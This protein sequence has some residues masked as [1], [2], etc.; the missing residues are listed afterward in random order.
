MI[1]IPR[2][3]AERHGL[4]V[5]DLSYDHTFN[6]WILPDD[7]WRASYLIL[8]GYEYWNTDWNE[9]KWIIKRSNW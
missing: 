6:S 1:L 8:M 7:D 9:T 2:V 4:K 5:D 3:I